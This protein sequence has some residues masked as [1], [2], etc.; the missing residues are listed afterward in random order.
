[1]SK[2]SIRADFC[3]SDIVILH[4]IRASP[5]FIRLETS[6]NFSNITARGTHIDIY[7]LVWHGTKSIWLEKKW[8]VLH[9]RKMF[10]TFGEFFWPNTMFIKCDDDWGYV[11][12]GVYIEVCLFIFAFIILSI[13]SHNILSKNQPLFQT[14]HSKK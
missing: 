12:W 4:T 6:K 10:I 1:M 5:A 2:I 11:V 8:S 13:F 3:W 14:Q 9:M 7:T